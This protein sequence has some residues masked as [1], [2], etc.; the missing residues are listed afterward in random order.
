MI[1]VF[2]DFDGVLFDSVKEAYLL[3]RCAYNGI[4][5]KTEIDNTE[6]NKFRKYRYLIT[7]SWHFYYI[8]KLILNNTP[9]DKFETE[10][11]KCMNN[12]NYSAVEEFDKKYVKVREDLMKS[13]FEFWD[14]LDTPF[15]FFF[16]IRELSED[17]NYKF[18]ILT[19]KKR[20]PVQNKLNKFSLN[21]ELFSN[22]DLSKYS[23]K[24]DFI[25]K[26]MVDNNIKKCYFVDDSMDNLNTCL[27]YNNIKSLLANW[28][29]IAPNQ[30]G[31]S[32]E[33]ITDII[34]KEM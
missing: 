31:Y 6:Y 26:Y 25:Q 1:T 2:L 3:S 28:G 30:K 12:I 17:N 21:A 7:K 5:V 34:I 19:N 18:I 11:K 33:E 10:Y 23:S 20:L 13:D 32:P 22:E 9:D 16:K 4:G 15:D 27:K 24:G 14:N 8:F 29:Y